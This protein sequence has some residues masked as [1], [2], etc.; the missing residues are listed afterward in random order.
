MLIAICAYFGAIYVLNSQVALICST[1]IIFAS[2]FGYK[3][4]ASKKLANTDIKDFDEFFDDEEQDLENSAVNFLK[5]SHPAEHKQNLN[6]HSITEPENSA[7][8]FLKNSE[9][10]ENSKNPKEILK[11]SKEKKLKIPFKFYDFL[12]A[13]SPLRIAAY[14]LLILAFFLLLRH[15][16]FEPLSFLA[17]LSIMPI[18]TLLAG[19]FNAHS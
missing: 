9:N 12:S 1:L 4:R 7:V 2:F 10:S 8:N 17:G 6:P 19:F 5:N 11:N 16:L 18:S 15:G 3:K 14:F 13:F